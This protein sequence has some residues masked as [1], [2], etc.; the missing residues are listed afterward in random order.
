MINTCA[1]ALYT[2]YTSQSEGYAKRNLDILERSPRLSCTNTAG[3][4]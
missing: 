4:S 1:E 3:N 2:F